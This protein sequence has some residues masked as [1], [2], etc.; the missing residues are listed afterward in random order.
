ME[1][2]KITPHQTIELSI[3][4]YIELLEIKLYSKKEAQK[5]D[6]SWNYGIEEL[7]EEIKLLKS[8]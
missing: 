3:T 1:K 7:E 2:Y 4:E 6:S 5:Q 8:I